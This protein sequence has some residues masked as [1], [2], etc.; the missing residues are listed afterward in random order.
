MSEGGFFMPISV[1]ICTFLI[2]AGINL[3]FVTENVFNALIFFNIL[4]SGNP[5]VKYDIHTPSLP[6]I[7]V[8]LG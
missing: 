4:R 3:R 1:K 5:G 7:Y 6:D 8:R 2:F